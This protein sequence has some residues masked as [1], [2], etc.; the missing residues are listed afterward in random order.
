MAG[1][2]APQ[3]EAD[4]MRKS[5]F[6]EDHFGVASPCWRSIGMMWGFEGGF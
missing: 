5:R 6:M 2:K 1:P 3:S 4:R